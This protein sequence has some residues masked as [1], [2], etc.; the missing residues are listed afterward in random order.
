MLSLLLL[1]ILYSRI[2]IALW[3]SSRGLERHIAMQNTTQLNYGNSSALPRSNSKYESAKRGLGASESQVGGFLC[4]V[5]EIGILRISIRL[6][7]VII[8][9]MVVLYSAFDASF[10]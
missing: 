5:V 2:A 6:R 3:K 9:I 10:R 7:V 8:C 1:Q 4:R